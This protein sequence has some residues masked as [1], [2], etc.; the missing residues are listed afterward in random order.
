MSPP[1]TGIPML[2]TRS[3]TKAK[4]QATTSTSTSTSHQR[5]HANATATDNGHRYPPTRNTRSKK[6]QATLGSVGEESSGGL[7]PSLPNADQGE[8]AEEPP[9]PPFIDDAP[10]LDNVSVEQFLV[11]QVSLDTAPTGVFNG[12]EATS[13]RGVQ[14]STAGLVSSTVHVDS[15]R[16]L[17]EEDE[18]IAGFADS[19][20]S[21]PH[22]VHSTTPSPSPP[23]TTQ[24]DSFRPSVAGGSLFEADEG[25]VPTRSI[26]APPSETGNRVVAQGMGGRRASLSSGSYAA[27]STGSLLRSANSVHITSYRPGSPPLKGMTHH[28]VST[29]SPG[30]FPP[31]DAASQALRLELQRRSEA[32][33]EK[34]QRISG[35]RPE[36]QVL[37]YSDI[38]NA[39]RQFIEQIDGEIS[40]I[41]AHDQSGY[42]RFITWIGFELRVPYVHPQFRGPAQMICVGVLIAIIL[43]YVV[44]HI[45][46][47][48]EYPAW[49][50]PPPLLP[51]DTRRFTTPRHRCDYDYDGP[52]V[53]RLGIGFIL[54]LRFAPNFHCHDVVDPRDSAKRYELWS[55]NA[56]LAGVFPGDR[57]E[58]FSLD[59]PLSNPRFDGSGG[60]WDFT[61]NPQYLEL[62]NL[63]HA[64]IRRT[65]S[66][67]LMT[68]SAEF[69][70]LTSHWES[71]ATSSGNIGVVSPDLREGL[72]SR[73]RNLMEQ[74]KFLARQQGLSQCSSWL[75][76]YPEIASYEWFAGLSR[77]S[78]WEAHVDNIAYFQRQLKELAAWVE[79]VTRLIE[80][81]FSINHTRSK[82]YQQDF[83]P[84]DERYL[85]VWVQGNHE[86]AVLWLL[87]CGV[88]CYFV[89]QYR[90]NFEYGEHIALDRRNSVIRGFVPQVTPI[91]LSPEH[92]PYFRMALDQAA[93]IS[94]SF[95][96]PVPY[97]F[98]PTHTSV[99]MQNKSGSWVHGYR[100]QVKSAITGT[101]T[102]P[103]TPPV[104][105]NGIPWIKPPP[106]LAGDRT[107][108]KWIVYRLQEICGQ[109]CMQEASKPSKRG[110]PWYDRENSRIL[111]FEGDLSPVPGLRGRSGTDDYGRP[112]PFY[113]YVGMSTGKS[114]WIPIAHKRTCW[115][116]RTQFSSGISIPEQAP[117]SRPKNR[118]HGSVLPTPASSQQTPPIS[119]QSNIPTQ[120]ETCPIVVDLP[121]ASTFNATSSED[122]MDVDGAVLLTQHPS[123]PANAGTRQ[124]EAV[125]PKPMVFPN[126]PAI[127]DQTAIANPTIIPNL[128]LQP[129]AGVSTSST[130]P[131][132]IIVGVD[133]TPGV[134]SNVGLIQTVSIAPVAGPSQ[135]QTSRHSSSSNHL[136]QHRFSPYP[137]KQAEKP[138]EPISTDTDTG[139]E[140]SE[141]TL[142]RILA[143][144]L[145]SSTGSQKAALQ[146]ILSNFTGGRYLPSAYLSVDV[147]P[148]NGVNPPLLTN[149][150]AFGTFVISSKTGFYLRYWHILYP[151][152]PFITLVC[153]AIQRGLHVRLTV[154]TSD[155][156]GMITTL[157]RPP[158]PAS[159][160]FPSG[161]SPTGLAK[162]SQKRKVDSHTRA[163]SIY[164]EGVRTMLRLPRARRLILEGG[165]LWR[166]ALQWDGMSLYQICL[167]G[168]SP[169]ALHYR[170]GETHPD[171]ELFDDGLPDSMINILLGVQDNGSS[172]WP[173]PA[174]LEYGGRW[175][176]LWNG[177]LETWFQRQ[178]SKISADGV[179]EIFQEFSGC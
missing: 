12:T 83:P 65:T 34:L 121:D 157:L 147:S 17:E 38:R 14:D 61:L 173:S 162:W 154:K 169:L 81:N 60:R 45:T 106:V 175:Y 30:F 104:G 37:L 7:A 150:L 165:L 67:S 28:Q 155:I 51:M 4:L 163:C 112:A 145:A 16:P 138:A 97:T 74:A 130:S 171:L 109:P 90:E 176:G 98:R 148:I 32:M 100:F 119:D 39:A 135:A 87:G 102:W 136:R 129:P 177:D 55:P 72:K 126:E 70:P 47:E 91:H 142:P 114:D 44:L 27:I 99:E 79:C 25:P 107:R 29:P 166:I 179:A 127:P 164:V 96:P 137:S 132:G 168:P 43:S 54:K 120:L 122:S 41:K 22:V 66:Y 152:L 149:G 15:N 105:P 172:F 86:E 2:N 111:F 48:P 118:N 116:Y 128:T 123:P 73:A 46:Q 58:N 167:N 159:E 18:L 174:L 141:L 117:P 21:I 143:D 49:E 59:L 82:L 36:A 77:P 101:I 110:L 3:V 94:H 178:A 124:N 146:Q 125:I 89:H 78:P 56:E 103:I 10:T 88:P 1:P 42:Q 75:P 13:G 23:A 92:N 108:K 5:S 134:G 8:A 69:W 64:F 53:F 113:N 85:G 170:V 144:A 131:S 68:D 93:P 40:T 80:T 161:I 115:I 158:P 133:N 139:A 71:R 95:D 62:G 156:R 140:L 84:G 63:H 19:P 33:S 26:M 160:V 57:P 151:D 6:D 24:A 9:V 76:P 153:M 35:L 11:S 20:P 50:N 52:R 31:I